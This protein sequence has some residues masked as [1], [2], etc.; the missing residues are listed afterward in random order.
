[1]D[2][3]QFEQLDVTD[4]TA[5]TAAIDGFRPTHVVH[6]AALTT[7]AAAED[8]THATW[9]LHLFGTLNIANAI[10]TLV[11]D[12]TLLFIGSGE[13]YG[14]SAQSGSPLD[15][16][17]VLAPM[18]EY[19]ATKAAADLALGAMVRKGLRSIRLRP[20]NHSGWGQSARFV[21]PSFAK[22]IADIESGEAS[23]VLKVGN[24]DAERDFLDVRDVVDAYT[25]AIAMS[26]S[27]A[28]GII[29]NIASGVPIRIHELLDKLLSL[30]KYSIRVEQDSARMRVNDV[31]RYIG[32][33]SRAK[34]LLSWSPRFQ[35]E[36]MLGEVLDY[37]RLDKGRKSIS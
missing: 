7:L 6:L 12:C 9:Q 2:G 5:V 19:A 27:L 11:P 29:L 13:I 21:I 8:D 22:Q 25:S 4:A 16:A 28:P 1:L 35:V 18:S 23:P 17:T 15:E 32:D 10:L 33:S 37:F 3:L 14:A 36:D 20:F 24:L 31:P 26:D 30:S 34:Q